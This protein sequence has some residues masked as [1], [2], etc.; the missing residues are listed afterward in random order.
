M[1]GKSGN[2]FLEGDVRIQLSQVAALDEQTNWI[3]ALRLMHLQP[4]R[5]GRWH[6]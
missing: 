2:I 5:G 1:P 6:E 3:P 4:M